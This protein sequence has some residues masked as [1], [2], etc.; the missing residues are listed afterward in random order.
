M[1]LMLVDSKFLQNNNDDDDND[2]KQGHP[3]WTA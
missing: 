2:D 1:Y 3:L